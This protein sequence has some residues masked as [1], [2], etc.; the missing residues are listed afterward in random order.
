MVEDLRHYKLDAFISD[1]GLG[2]DT[3][4]FTND[5]SR[6]PPLVELTLTGYGLQKNNT[7]LTDQLNYL[8]AQKDNNSYAQSER[9][10]WLA[11]NYQIKT[12][13]RNLTGENGT[14]NVIVRLKNKLFSYKDENGEIL[15][16]EISFLYGF[17][18]ENGYNLNF[19]EADTYDN[20]IKSLK[21]GSADIAAGFFQ[22]RNDKR[23]EIN[24]S[25][26]M[27]PTL[28]NAYVRYENLEENIKWMVHLNYTKVYS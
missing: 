28:I 11:I 15:G 16:S 24:F 19:I 14:L 1:D 3:Q 20:Q 12:L 25:N 18:K 5:I 8:L 10:K 22:I 23:D 7:E 13:D 26:L 17:S 6:F 27:H 2:N 4:M 21:N 9:E